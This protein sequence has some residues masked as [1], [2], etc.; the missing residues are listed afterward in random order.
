MALDDATTA[1]LTEAAKAGGPPLH[2]MTV[3]QAR[4]MNA[5]LDALFG[6]GPE[7]A[8]VKD[9]TLETADGGS[10]PVRVFRPDAPK[11]VIVYYHGG[12]WMLGTLSGF[13]TLCRQMADRTGMTVVL[14]EYRKAPEDR[15]PAAADDAW[16]A[17]RWV[18]ANR[19][20]L[21]DPGLPL[22]VGGDSAGGNL[23]A[24]V[25]QR[26]AQEGGPD[27][28]LQILVYP[29]TDADFETETYNDPQ[30]ALML[31]KESMVMFWDAYL[32]DAAERS[33]PAAAPLRGD[34]TGT[35]QALVILAE[36][37]VLRGEGA[38]YAAKLREAGIPVEEHVIP[39]Q[40]HGFFTFPN[41]LPGAAAGM[42]LV[43]DAVS[44][45]G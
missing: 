18:V 14:V 34:V 2:A 3:E 6:Q 19:P 28:D 1:F 24:V 13:D 33:N 5:G 38:A 44:R 43:V 11:G 27:I 7:I 15:F 37:D 4:E 16:T 35:P 26:A 32:P 41:V 42:D 45:L 22:V 23:T 40:M 36:H 30:N 31:T 21:A 20:E 8:L 12:G 10:F 9:V 25:A 29:V 17:L 39:G